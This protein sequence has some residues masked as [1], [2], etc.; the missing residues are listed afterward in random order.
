MGRTNGKETDPMDL[1]HELPP[2]EEPESQ[3]EQGTAGGPSQAE[4]EIEKLRA[5][6]ME[7]VQRLA[8]MQ[9]EFENARRRALREQQDFKEY[10]LAD[11]IRSLLPVVDSFDRALASNASGENFR[12]GMELI[13]RQLH[14][15]LARL[16][17][18]A[19]SAEGQRF[20]PSQHEA[21]EMVE[22]DQVP[23]HHVF[24]E[25]QKG[26]RLKDRLLRPAMVRVANNPG[27]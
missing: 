12:A 7:L 8:R 18:T 5:E 13:D 20:D 14:D 9:A 27:K 15:A 16:G 19:V 10:A 23:D 21:I 6:N 22:T 3:G 24:Q 25:L 17:V 11:A 1:E 26:Y 4:A 2:A